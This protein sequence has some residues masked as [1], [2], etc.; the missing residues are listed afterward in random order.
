MGPPA[1]W[2]PPSDS[3]LRRITATRGRPRAVSLEM[4]AVCDHNF[5]ENARAVAQAAER[6]SICMMPGVKIMTREEIHILDIAGSSTLWTPD[7]CGGK[8]R[9]PRVARQPAASKSRHIRRLGKPCEA[10]LPGVPPRRAR[11]APLPRRLL[12]A[13][14]IFHNGRLSCPSTTVPSEPEGILRSR[15]PHVHNVRPPWTNRFS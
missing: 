12:S 6:A 10:L 8:S 2:Q 14:R 15:R 13:H 9:R 3:L 1:A 4:I 7:S 11:R 5:V